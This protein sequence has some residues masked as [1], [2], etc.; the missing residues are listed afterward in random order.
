MAWT[1]RLSLAVSVIFLLAFASAC[2]SNH[3]SAP[4][5]APPAAG[6]EL[7][8]FGELVG[9]NWTGTARFGTADGVVDTADASLL[10]VWGSVCDV[11][12]WCQ[13][14]YNEYGWGTTKGIRTRIRGSQLSAGY[15]RTLDVGET[16]W[17]NGGTVEGTG[18]WQTARLSGDGQR[19][20]IESS[21]F[22]WQGR[23]GVTF[24]LTRAPW[25]PDFPCPSLVS[26]RYE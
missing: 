18:N 14:G 12:G 8:T 1:A 6:R 11:Y 2:N 21:D 5:P 17:Q 25:P 19:L 15:W 24:E 9:T 26:C 23:H 16:L 13:Q 4:S 22:R 10:F 3:P 20:V 7:A